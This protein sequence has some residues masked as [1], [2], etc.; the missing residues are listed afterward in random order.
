MV[1]LE[2]ASVALRAMM[3]SIRFCFIAPLANPDTTKLLFLHGHLQTNIGVLLWSKAWLVR[4]A[5]RHLDE[6]SFLCL[7]IF[8]ILMHDL[9]WIF[10]MTFNHA[11]RKSWII[12][13]WLLVFLSMAVVSLLITTIGLACISTHIPLFV[14]WNVSWICSNCSHDCNQKVK[15][16]ESKEA[17]APERF[18][19]VHLNYCFIAFP[20]F[21]EWNLWIVSGDRWVK[22][23]LNKSCNDERW[24]EF[25]HKNNKRI[26]RC[27]SRKWLTLG[28]ETP[29]YTTI[30]QLAPSSGALG[31]QS[32]LELAKQSC[33]VFSCHLYHL[34]NCPPNF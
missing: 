9:F 3:A 15:G 5:T 2:D 19:T 32:S 11:I 28:S 4:A 1:H 16:E 20:D 31:P 18:V 13:S 10:H 17:C 29:A 34:K 12:R 33:H 22:E 27:I 14:V 8:V 30:S 23:E 25:L 24:A 26:D 7:Q 21:I 6:W